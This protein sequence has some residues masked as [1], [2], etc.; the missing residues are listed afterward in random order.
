LKKERPSEDVDQNVRSLGNADRDDRPNLD[1]RQAPAKVGQ[2]RDAP[3]DYTILSV[4]PEVAHTDAPTLI[5]ISFSPI[6]PEFA[7]VRFG[8]V[9]VAGYVGSE[10]GK[11][12]CNSPLHRNGAVKL[13]ISK[14][15]VHFFGSADFAF[16]GTGR[17]S[18]Q[19][20]WGLGVMAGLVGVYI[21]VKRRR[22]RRKRAKKKSAGVSQKDPTGKV[23][24]ATHRQP[25]GTL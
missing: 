2:R 17:R 3:Q 4:S 7:F 14:D 21:V 5:V 20:L 10:D 23:N 8:D 19:W 15:G 1:K 13:S 12:R 6:D 25:V 11:L 16:V 24:G 9:A 22:R 18:R